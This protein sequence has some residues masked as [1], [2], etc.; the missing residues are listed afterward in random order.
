MVV[1]ATAVVSLP[2]AAGLLLLR[3]VAALGMVGLAGSILAGSWLLTEA[4]EQIAH[5]VEA[6]RPLAV[7]QAGLELLIVL[8]AAL[9]GAAAMWLVLGEGS[10]AR[11]WAWLLDWEPLA[12]WRPLS[13]LATALLGWILAGGICWLIRATFTLVLRKEALGFGDVHIIAAAG[14]VLGPHLAITGF[15]LAAPV[16]L[17]G[18]LVLA[19]RKRYRTVPF[20]PWLAMGLLLA[21]LWG[22][23]LATDIDNRITGAIR[24]MTG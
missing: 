18:M 11:G 1:A 4:D 5:A 14:A 10:L 15:F 23:P 7:R 16:A 12:G 9:A 21:T 20:G 19:F 8:V 13:G 3:L 2:G 24:L 6:E 17:L 22:R